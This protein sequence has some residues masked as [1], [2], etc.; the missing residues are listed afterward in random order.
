MSWFKRGFLLPGTGKILHSGRHTETHHGAGVGGIRVAW[1]DS[2]GN[3][4]YEEMFERLK[5]QSFL[6]NSGTESGNIRRFS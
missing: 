6:K 4:G 3:F 2:A 5:D 1:F